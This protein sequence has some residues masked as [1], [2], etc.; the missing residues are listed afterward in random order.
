V[1]F[2]V[3][4]GGV[5]SRAV[6]FGIGAATAPVLR[7]AQARHD[8]TA[9]LEANEWRGAVEPRPVIRSL[10][11]L[12]RD[13]AAADAE[14][15]AGW[16]DAAW[17]AYESP[18]PRAPVCSEGTERTV[19]DRRGE[20]AVGVLGDLM[21]TT[22]PLIVLCADVSRRAAL[23]ERDLGPE[24]F[25]RAPWARLS[26]GCGR[27]AFERAH[28]A[29]APVLCEYTALDPDRALLSRFTHVF[30]L[31]PPPLAETWGSL[32]R[33]AGG[34]GAF[35]HLGFGPAEMEFARRVWGHEHA[36]RPHLEAVYRALVALGQGSAEVSRALLAG[37]GKYPR[38]PVVAGRCLRVL[39]ELSLAN[40]D[41]SSGTLRCTITNSGRADL[42]RSQTF[43]ASARAAEEGHRFLETLT[44]E[45]PNATV[46]ARAA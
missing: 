10:H 27:D 32:R 43:R 1:R 34:G 29:A 13:G 9:R 18:E 6:G 25:G 44:P 24:R 33:S 16:W 35:L 45:T 15:D 40:L 23:M 12:P 21:T 41:R 28:A 26:A 22:E 31:D 42:E 8:L 3:T 19:V 39:D 11:S 7:D 17:A 30:T 4:S 38:S 37:E 36:L 5:R 20:G 2:T 46:T 14:D